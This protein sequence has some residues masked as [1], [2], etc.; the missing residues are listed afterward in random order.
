MTKIDQKREV[1]EKHILY[2]NVKQKDYNYIIK[3]IDSDIKYYKGVS[4]ALNKILHPYIKVSYYVNAKYT[5]L[6]QYHDDGK[7]VTVIIFGDSPQN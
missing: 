6:T 7:Q 3:D 5:A 2:T 1:F 4:Y